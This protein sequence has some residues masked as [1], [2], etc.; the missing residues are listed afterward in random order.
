M[1]RVQLSLLLDGS[2]CRGDRLCEHLAAENVFRLGGIAAAIQIFFDALDV[3]Q[4][5]D[6]AQDRIHGGARLLG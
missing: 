4:I 1:H 6:V 3:E 5:D 2:V